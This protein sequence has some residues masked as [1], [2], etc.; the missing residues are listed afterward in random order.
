M[1]LSLKLTLEEANAILQTLGELPS[2]TGVW[3]LIVKIKSQAESQTQ[4]QAQADAA[5]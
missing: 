1:E 3:P 5:T 4:A 2:R